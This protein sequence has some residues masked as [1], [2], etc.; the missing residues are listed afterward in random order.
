[1]DPIVAAVHQIAAGAAPRDAIT[2]HL[3]ACRDLF[4][5]WGLTSEIF[6]EHISPK[7]AGNVLDA[8]D[9]AARTS[10]GDLAI[11]H[12]SIQ[13]AA[14]EIAA[15]HADRCAFHYHNITP[16]SHLWRYAPLVAT[17]CARGRERL[18]DYRDRVVATWADSQF[19]ADELS[20]LGYEHPTAIGI[21]RSPH[22]RSSTPS[23]EE[24]ATA[25]RML[26]VGRGIPNKA[27]HDL[28]LTLAALRDAHV[29]AT[30]TLVGSWDAAPGYR[31][32]CLSLADRLGVRSSLI[33][34]G[35]VSDES[36]AAEYRE[37]NVFVCLSDH[38]GFCVPVLEAID[39]ELPI[40][41]YAAGAVPETVGAAGL[42]LPEKPPSLV[43][44]AVLEVTRNASLRAHF[45]HGR[46]VQRAH[47]APT[48]VGE[49]IRRALDA[50]GAIT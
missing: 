36:L 43:A 29:D 4:R 48:A 19:N 7:L 49:R 34:L 41:A 46:A 6:A 23:P 39:A 1:V 16:A 42:L 26:F 14:F 18:S 27:Q 50:I 38:E 28:V 35:S 21:L 20:E 8:K 44:E 11:L 13:S 2:N 37:A 33:L 3:L 45:A 47:F 24:P 31:D 32:L 10:P 5:S 9:Y 12:Y 17:E 15:D 22:G 25:V 30:L 40:V